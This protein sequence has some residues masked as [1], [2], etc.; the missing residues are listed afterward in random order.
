MDDPKVNVD[1]CV[2]Q[3]RDE[4]RMSFGVDARL[5]HPGVQGSEIDVMALLTRGHAMVQLDGIGATTTEGVTRVERLYELHG[6]HVR[7][8]VGRGFFEMGPLTFPHFND[9]V[10]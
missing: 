9:I 10:P 4:A 6:I 8:D 2:T 3:L 1:V 7:L 5:V